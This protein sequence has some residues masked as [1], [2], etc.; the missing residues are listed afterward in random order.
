MATLTIAWEYLTG[1]AVATDPTTRDRAEWPPHPARVFMALAAAWAETEL[2]EAG[3]ARRGEWTAERAALRWLETLGDPEMRLPT[4]GNDSERSNVTYYVPVNDKAGPSAATLQSCPALTRSK[5]ARSFPRCWVGNGLCVLYWPVAENSE[6][7][8]E[9]L[10]RLCRKVTRLGHSSSLI[11]MRVAEDS[12]LNVVGGIHLVPDALQSQK[13]VRSLS[14]GTLDMLQ[15]R[16]GEEA[17]R[18]HAELTQTLE[19]LK[20]KRRTITGKGAKELKDEIDGQ[21]QTL[22]NELSGIV[23]RPPVRPTTGLWTGYRE[24]D[25]RETS[26]EEAGQ[27]L[28]D[29]EILVLARVG[30]PQLPV[31]STFAVLKALRNKILRECVQPVPDWV[32]GHLPDGQPLR[33]GNRHM[34]LIPLAYVGSEHADG[35][36]IGAAIV[37]PRSVPRQERGRVLG[38]MLVEA[39]GLPKP[40]TLDLGS[41]GKWEVRKRDWE[42][43]RYALQP[44]HW[45]AAENDRGVPR[46]ATTWASVTPVVLDRFPKHDR[47]DPTQRPDWE[48]EVE[49]VLRGACTRIGLP[50]PEAVDIDTTSWHLGSP[51]AFGKRRP[52]RGPTGF[53]NN[54]DA[55]LGDG[56]P[57]YP[58]KGTNAPRPQLHVWLRF[59]RPVI[60]P[61]LLGA[62]RFL[63]YG[64]C[65]PLREV[66]T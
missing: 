63:G 31:V 58:A 57:H 40:V 49:G 3:D 14:R 15:E 20:V 12:E 27:T 61:V 4:V 19:T 65:K 32:S 22:E 60:G 33:D 42:E 26:P 16:F 41:L 53:A 36:L 52:L 45:T 34:A 1:Y 64:L 37:F 30:G 39:N 66:R 38:R 55:A 23:P 47:S 13:R 29:P 7:H 35:H 21:I 17:R 8:R 50:E 54:A 56:F 43:R 44:G 6:L 46:G 59:A 51:R 25:R 11:A 24:V 18:R 28:F 10:G 9:A 48:V 5:Q 62:G 2:P